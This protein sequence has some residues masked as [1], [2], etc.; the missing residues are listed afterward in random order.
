MFVRL[1]SVPAG[2]GLVPE[3]QKF[4]WNCNDVSADMFG[5]AQ[6]SGEWWAGGYV[7]EYEHARL[8]QDADGI[9]ARMISKTEH[10]ER[11]MRQVAQQMGIDLNG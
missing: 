7:E 1:L 9:A 4:I 8:V 6:H 11:V 10:G 2:S 5:A 3:W